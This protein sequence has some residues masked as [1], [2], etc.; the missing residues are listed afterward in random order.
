MQWD[1]SEN[2]GFTRGKPWLKVNRNYKYINYASQKHNPDSVLNFYKALI[3]FRKEHELA[4]GEFMP[5]HADDRIMLYLRTSGNN[6]KYVVALNFSSRKINLTKKVA[7]RLNGKIHFSSSGRTALD[8][9][10]LPWEGVLAG[11]H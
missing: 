1:G 5:L 4:Y 6:E 10:L 8:G 7:G 2:A 9:Y 3:A 11:E